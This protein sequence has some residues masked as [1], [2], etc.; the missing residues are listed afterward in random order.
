M[1]AFVGIVSVAAW[2]QRGQVIVDERVRVAGMFAL[3]GAKACVLA[4]GG[5]RLRN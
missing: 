4:T 5:R 2:R 3:L 1:H